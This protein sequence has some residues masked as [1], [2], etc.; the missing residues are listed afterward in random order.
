MSTAIFVG[1]EGLNLLGKNQDVP[2]ET[3]YLFTNLRGV[4][5]R[6]IVMLPDQPAEWVSRFGSIT[7]SQVGKEMP[8]GGMNEA[9]LVVE[10]TTLW[11]SSYP[12]EPDLPAVG[13]VQWIQLLL[14][15]CA[16]V[17]EALEAAANIRIVQP[18]SRLHY[19]V[20]DREGSCVII[21]FIEGEMVAYRNESLPV[22]VL[23]N[24]PYAEACRDLDDEDNNW[25]SRYDD[26]ARNSMDRFSSAAALAAF[27]ASSVPSVPSVT[28]ATSAQSTAANPIDLMFGALQAVQRED[29]AFSLVYNMA[30]LEIYFSSNQHPAQKIIQLGEMDF[31]PAAHVMAWN[32]QQSEGGRAA[33]V[34]YDPNLNYT[35]VEAFFRD[36]EL[37]AAFGWNISEEMITYIASFPNH[38]PTA[39]E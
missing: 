37:T 13:E 26:Y 25:H 8:N 5:K 2:Y 15:T 20:S 23:T 19:V 6:A 35:I 33:T 22:P 38:Y 17:E 39:R 10:Q 16:N 34:R 7:I 14:D 9:G 24:T 3:A 18:M 30:K 12:T 28:S 21:E 27:P 1:R 32:V 4:A 36:P 31:S 11:Q 29:T